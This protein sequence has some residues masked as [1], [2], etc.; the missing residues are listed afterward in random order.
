MAIVRAF[1]KGDVNITRL[2]YAMIILISKEEEAKSLKKFRPISLMNY[3]FKIF[4]KT[5]NSRL[6]SISN[7]LPLTNMLLSKVGIFW[8]A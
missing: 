8:K 1:E 5:L 4:A 7:C 3:S 2:N 6:E